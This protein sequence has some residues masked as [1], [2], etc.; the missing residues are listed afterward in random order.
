MKPRRKGLIL[1]SLPFLRTGLIAAA[2][3]GS[4]RDG[5]AE[6][7]PQ[8]TRLS[9]RDLVDA[10]PRRV[11]PPAVRLAVDDYIDALCTR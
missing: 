9:L 8:S 10:H 4:D 11:N 7:A 2:G 6:A 3:G 1:R 5:V